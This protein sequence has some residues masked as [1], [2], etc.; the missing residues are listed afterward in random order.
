MIRLQN[1]LVG[2]YVGLVPSPLKHAWYTAC[3]EA[4]PIASSI[5]I[6]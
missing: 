6:E 1:W 2:S 3:V 5:V 4:T